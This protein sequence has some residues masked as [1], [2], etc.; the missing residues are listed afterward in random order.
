[1]GMDLFI[2]DLP[3]G[4]NLDFQIAFVDAP[5]IESEFMVFKDG[6]NP[7]KFQ[8]VDEKEMIVMG[9]FMIADL[10]IPRYDNVR[11]AY[12]VKFPA[13]SINKIVENFSR[14]GIN[15][16]LNEMHKTND[17]SRDCFVL[18]H[19]QI[20]SAKEIFAPKGFKQEADRSWFGVVKCNNKEI[21]Q[22]ALNGEYTGFSIEGRFT[23]EIEIFTQL[24]EIFKTNKM[25]KQTL[26]D[27]FK[28][29]FNANP[30]AKD[31]VLD[32]VNEKFEMAKL[33]DGT[34][35]RIEPSV[36]IGSAM[37]VMNAE[38]EPIPAPIGEYQL[39]DGRVI[40]VAVEGVI[41]E[42]KEVES[43]EDPNAPITDE[44]MSQDSEQKVKRIIESIVKEKIFEVEK[45]NTFLKTE[46]ETLKKDFVELQANFEKFKTEQVELFEGLKT[47]SKETFE[48]LLDEPTKEPVSKKF[49]LTG[50]PKK[51]NMF[52]GE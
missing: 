39:E 30:D 6:V 14:N 48:A 23:E 26:K 10:E 51:K 24:K 52:T 21:Y 18:N 12:N 27:K 15:K 5:A 43:E 17:F 9:Y 34:E 33:V 42:I 28:E 4:E 36:E 13:K 45:V 38:G 32:V 1:M 40:V 19:W 46:N 7:Y 8:S 2:L 37:V 16:N 47:F 29:F 50:E 3:D 44:P 41:A 20:D 11:G 25:S 31:V 35:V 22:K 49:S